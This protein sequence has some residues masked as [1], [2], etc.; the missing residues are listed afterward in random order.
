MMFFF[1]SILFQI[2]LQDMLIDEFL[3]RSIGYVPSDFI[4]D[5]LP[6]FG[7]KRDDWKGKKENIR[8]MISILIKLM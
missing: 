4:R 2:P 1:N 8:A 5:G 7:S 6:H 3:L